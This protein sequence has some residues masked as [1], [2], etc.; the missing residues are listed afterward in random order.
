MALIGVA[1]FGRLKEFVMRT[2]VLLFLSVLMLWD[3]PGAC[4][5]SPQQ[6][7]QDKMALEYRI[8]AKD[9]LEI[10]VLGEDKLTTTARVS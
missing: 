10:R 5:P 7:R 8:G 9:L 6:D 4:L 2:S 1:G 3:V